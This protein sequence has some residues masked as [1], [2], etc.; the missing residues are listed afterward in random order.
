M[1]PDSS[2]NY[3]R[4]HKEKSLSFFGGCGAPWFL[5]CPCP[6]LSCKWP[7]I[8]I[9]S[10]SDQIAN[11]SSCSIKSQIGC[12]LGKASG[13]QETATTNHGKRSESIT[14]PWYAYKIILKKIKKNILAVL[15]PCNNF[16]SQRLRY[17]IEKFVWLTFIILVGKYTVGPW[18]L[19]IYEA[20]SMNKHCIP[21]GPQFII[22]WYEAVHQHL[23]ALY[24]IHFKEPGETSSITL[25]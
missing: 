21:N 25:F 20:N 5:P 9:V 3:L 8:A 16:Q 10:L 4:L 7:S 14:V 19:M 22:H 2:F 11:F 13:C 17:R 15:V 18:I 1:V 12:T 23:H 24:N 6:Q